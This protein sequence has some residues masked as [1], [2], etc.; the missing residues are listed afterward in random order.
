QPSR[1]PV[2]RALGL[3]AAT[4]L[5]AEDLLRSARVFLV[6][7]ALV[8]GITSCVRTFSTDIP[9]NYQTVLES[10]Y[11]GRV[12]WTRATLSDEKKETAKIEQDQEV[13]ID[14]LGMQRT[15]SVTVTSTVG[16]KRVVYP[17]HLKRPLSLE[18]YEKTLLDYIWLEPPEQRFDANKQKYGTR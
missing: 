18:M 8:L 16:H 4:L 6:V 15:G 10:K 3:E 5:V 13:H 7:A 11:V 14:E 1:Q 9:V 17:F 12:G 2:A